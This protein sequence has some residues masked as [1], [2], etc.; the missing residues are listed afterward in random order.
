MIRETVDAIRADVQT[1]LPIIKAALGLS[2][3]DVAKEM[4]V[5]P[6][7]FSRWLRGLM[8]SDPCARAVQRHLPR[9]KRKALAA[10]EKSA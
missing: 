3:N 7:V 6:S 8:T 9:L 4:D 2:Q 5:H 1:W 10:R